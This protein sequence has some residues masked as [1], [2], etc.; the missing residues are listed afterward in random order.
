[1]N[2]TESELDAATGPGYNVGIAGQEDQAKFGVK[3]DLLKIVKDLRMRNV[4]T[5]QDGFYRCL[6][7]PSFMMHMR[8]DKDFREIARYPGTGLINPLQSYLHPT[9]INYLNTGPA[10][11]GAGSVAGAPAMPSGFVFEGVRFFETTNMPDYYFNV[12]IEGAVGF[13]G[14]AAQLTQAAVGFFFGP[15]AIGLGVG[16][17]NAQVLTNSNDDFSRFIILIWQLY[18]GW[19]ILNMDFVTICHSF[20]YQTPNRT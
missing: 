9:A 2:L 14:N 19:E 7:D 1:M 3:N 12:S 15:Q 5:Y 4:P 8:Q 10:Y 16:G 13:V 20:I 17:N 6:C 18:A 11:G